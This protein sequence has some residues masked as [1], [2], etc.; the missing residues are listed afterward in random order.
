MLIHRIEYIY[1]VLARLFCAAF[2]PVRPSVDANLNHPAKCEKKPRARREVQFRLRDVGEVR[3]RSQ[4]T[5]TE[6]RP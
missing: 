5:H 3:L 4:L 2:P 1:E 6:G